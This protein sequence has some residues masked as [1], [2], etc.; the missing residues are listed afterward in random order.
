MDCII[1]GRKGGMKLAKGYGRHAFDGSE[2]FY[3]T[4][5]DRGR[6]RVCADKVMAWAE[7]PACTATNFK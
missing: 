1:A 6:E 5:G 4:S 2:Y 3:M 7:I